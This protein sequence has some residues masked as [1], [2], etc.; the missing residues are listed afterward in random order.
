MR[1]LCTVTVVAF[2]LLLNG[3]QSAYYGAMEQVGYHKRDIMVDRVEEAKASQQEA[4]QQ[5]SSALEEMQA[6]LNHDGGDLETAYNQAKDE[7]EAAQKVA[8]EVSSRI[9]D[10]ADV[11]D[12]LF[13]EWKTEIAEISKASLRRN[14]SAKLTK[15]KQSYKQLMT[16]MRGAESKMQPV[17]ISMKDNMLYLKH[18]LNAQAIGAIKGEFTNLQTDIAVLIKDMNKSIAESSQFIATLEGN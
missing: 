15:T 13:N 6:L 4:Q 14:S 18:N 9:N 7:Y 1:I 11:A 5:F 3:C 2:A 16:T 10:V 8:D 17:L 12:A